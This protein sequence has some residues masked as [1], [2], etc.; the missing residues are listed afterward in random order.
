MITDL[1][2]LERERAEASLLTL[3][4]ANELLVQTIR[5]VMGNEISNSL[6]GN[7]VTANEIILM[8]QSRFDRILEKQ[9]VVDASA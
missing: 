3:S 5:E 4:N 6:S 1:S 8:A 7:T 2:P 9:P